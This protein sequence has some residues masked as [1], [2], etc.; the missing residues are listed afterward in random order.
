MKKVTP[1]SRILKSLGQHPTC[2]KFNTHNKIIV[3]FFI[4]ML[5]LPQTPTLL[6][7]KLKKNKGPKMDS[8][9]PKVPYFFFH[10]NSLRGT[11]ELDFRK[12]CYFS[13]KNLEKKKQL[14]FFFRGKSL[15]GTTGKFK[16][17]IFHDLKLPKKGFFFSSNSYPR[18]FLSKI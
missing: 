9:S 12:F 15:Q 8:L 10:R 7:L 6:Y 17:F 13:S 11:D 1:E 14:F 4:P 16:F 18:E 5:L 3:H 2:P